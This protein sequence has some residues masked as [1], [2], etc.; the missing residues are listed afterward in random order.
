M[1][2]RLESALAGALAALVL[3]GCAGGETD[4]A[5]SDPAAS[6]PQA[7]TA[8][9]TAAA[10]SEEAPSSARA[11]AS[12]T[13][14]G[15]A[16]LAV[17]W[18]VPFTVTAPADWTRG[19]TTQTAT[20]ILDGTGLRSVLSAFVKSPDTPA[21]WVER[22]TTVESLDASEPEPIEIGG[23]P[24]QV[25]DVRLNE[26]GPECVAGGGTL[27]GVCLPIHGPE[28]GYVWVIE[29]DRP[30]RIWVLDVGGQTLVLTTDA[31]EDRFEDWAA[32][33]DEVLATVEWSEP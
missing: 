8:A 32:T 21:Q 22:L 6:L 23:A 27:G 10:A 1:S 18:A 17:E 13:P 19:V 26:L 28:D 7:S 14:V 2:R 11:S 29:D 31:R 20:E 3:V 30:A 24:G 5:G 12:A 9:S 4:G 33:M 25:F 16:E 15:E